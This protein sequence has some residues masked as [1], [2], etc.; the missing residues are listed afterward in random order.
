MDKR[1][2]I[3]FIIF[4]CIGI[5][6]GYNITSSIY[7][8]QLEGMHS[9]LIST[10]AMLS[11]WKENNQTVASESWFFISVGPY[12]N[13]THRCYYHT[14]GCEAELKNEQLSY[15]IQDVDGS[16]ILQGEGNTGING[17][18]DLY[19]PLNKIYRISINV[20]GLEGEATITTFPESLSCI[21][22][23]KAG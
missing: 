12:Q 21:T 18:L 8:P 1:N 14:L 15:I 9:S 19:L 2:I 5:A 22:T 10:Q 16:F 4:L 3:N 23:L 17:F 11:G 7:Q 20:K 6:I 13:E